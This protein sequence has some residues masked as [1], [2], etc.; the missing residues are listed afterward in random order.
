MMN[1]LYRNMLFGWQSCAIVG[2]S[3]CGTQG[4][5]FPVGDLSYNRY[6]NFINNVLGTPAIHGQAECVGHSTSHR[7][8][9][10]QGAS[11]V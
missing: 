10:C 3:G 9:T 6:E 8:S 11:K 1:T 2:T 4:N 7:I 5:L